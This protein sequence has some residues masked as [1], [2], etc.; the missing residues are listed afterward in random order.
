MRGWVSVPDTVLAISCVALWIVWPSGVY[1]Q[2][3]IRAP[4]KT[5]V[6]YAMIT[7][8][9]LKL[10]N[11]PDDFIA[12]GSAGRER[13]EDAKAP[14]QLILAPVRPPMLLERQ[15]FAS[16]QKSDVA[17]VPPVLTQMDEP[18]I[19][20]SIEGV[21]QEAADTNLHVFVGLSESLRKHN[22]Q[23]PEFKIEASWKV[24]D[25]WMVVVYVET[26]ED[27]EPEHVFLE[28][29]CDDKKINDAAVK[30]VARGRASEPAA[31]CEGR[32]TINYGTR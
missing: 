28:T 31:R 1:E 23:M 13:L 18:R 26:N 9:D 29:G 7:P 14:E 19:L 27:G 25:S 4:S 11:R 16:I 30:L 21:F 5:M 8:G 32:V 24:A 6:G 17:P 2:I 10:L 20:P 3:Q 12:L 22:F 15:A